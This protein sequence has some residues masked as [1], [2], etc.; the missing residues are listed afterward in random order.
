[1]SEPTSSEILQW[2]LINRARLDPAGEAVRAGIPHVAEGGANI[3]GVAL[4]ATSKQPLAWNDKLG[5]Y[6]DKHNSEMFVAQK[7]IFHDNVATTE[8]NIR[9]EQYQ[10]RAWGENISK[11]LPVNGGDLTTEMNAQALSLFNDTDV[12]SRGHRENILDDKFQEVGVGQM[13]G[14]MQGSNR[15]IVTESFGTP[16]AGGQFLTGIAYNDK[17]ANAFYSI[18]E[19]RGGITV[20]TTAGAVST[21][22]AGQFSKAISAGVQT[23]SFS[24]GDLAAPVSVSINVTAGRNA[25]VDLVDKSTVETSVSLTA[26]SGVTRIIGLGNNGLTLTGNGL[27]NTIVSALGNDAI[28]GGG[29]TDTVAYAGKSGAYTITDNKNGTFTVRGAEGTDTLTSIEKLQFSDKQVVLSGP[30]A[31]AGNV[32]IGDVSVAEGANGTKI[33]NFVITRS[34]GTAAFDLTFKTQDGSAKASEGDYAGKSNELVRFAAGEMSKTVSVVING[35]GKVEGD[36]TFSALISGAT[37]GAVIKD[38]TGIGKIVNDDVAAPVAGSIAI[39]DVTVTEGDSGTKVMSFTVTRTDGTAA[40]DVDFATKAGT[41]SAA[42]GDYVA[43]GNTLHFNA[44]ETTKTI[45]VV[46]NGDT[47]VEANETFKLV[48]SNATN[49]AKIADNTGIG[50]I[51]NTDTAAAKHGADGDFNGNGASDILFQ[52]TNGKVAMWQ[53]DGTKIMSNTSVTTL[54]KGWSIE[55]SGDF[56]GDGKADVLTHS[57]TG[58]AGVWQMN[59]DKVVSSKGVGSMD[60]SWKVVGIDDF[61][62]DGKSDVLW[63]SGNKLA[64]WQMDGDKVVSNQTFGTVGNGWSVQGTGDF[65][66]DGKADILL[67]NGGQ[68]AMWTMSGNQ[69]GQV[70]TFGTI[71]SGFEVAAVA[72]FNGDG[73]DDI[74]FHDARSGKVV[75]WQMN[76]TS[77]GSEATIGTTARGWEIID[78]GDYNHDGKADLLLQN[79]SGSLATWQ[80]DGHQIKAA[81]AIGAVTTDWHVT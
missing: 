28:N 17:D 12:A 61:G 52:N 46:V 51:L 34:E 43:R 55:G 36:E 26:L 71:A 41:A 37:N 56:N 24:G 73:K 40:F 48:L 13:T 64:M 49:G 35:D 18:G 59:G 15:S 10:F 5:N 11:S 78:T 77:I 53:M 29:G 27:D 70:K 19:G 31:V 38:G 66:G 32:S 39:N 50:T 47:K 4:D 44:G 72:D 62:G 54:S 14:N 20:T 74:M 23:V 9:N 69:V 30:A 65:N 3:D 25:L 6:A 33:M 2:A 58:A 68:V 8:Q 63:Q 75:E 45:E 79:A 7:G 81:Q 21:G 76:G 16:A 57:A 22:S 1:M 80:M 67:Q 42:D 60:T